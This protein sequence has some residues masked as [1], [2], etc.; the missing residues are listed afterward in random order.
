MSSQ[1]IKAEEEE[2]DIILIDSSEK[3][4]DV[5][6]VSASAHEDILV[7][8]KKAF[9][10]SAEAESKAKESDESLEPEQIECG[11][12]V[13]NFKNSGSKCPKQF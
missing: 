8:L 10:P 5:I 3:K 4:E 13:W 12:K 9:T 6:F 7:Q 11:D 1:P 2:E